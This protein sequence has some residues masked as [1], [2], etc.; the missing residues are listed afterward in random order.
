MTAIATLTEN[1]TGLAAGNPITTASTIFDKVSGAGSSAF[2][3]D[4]FSGGANRMMRVTN[5]G[6]QFRIHEMDFAAKELLWFTFD[7]AIEDTVDSNTAILNG[8]QTNAATAAEKIF[9]LQ[10]VGGATTLRLRSINTAIWTS[11]ALTADTKYRVYV[12]VK[13][14]ASARRLRVMVYDAAGT[15]LLQD[16]GELTATAAAT[17]ISHLRLGT[18]SDS[19]STLLFGRLR[20]DDADGPAVEVAPAASVSLATNKPTP[21]PGETVTLTAATTGTGT[22]AFTQT[23][24]PTVTLSG[25]GTTRTFTAPTHWP[26]GSAPTRPTLTFQ[27]AYGG[28]TQAVTVTPYAHTRWRK[29]GSGWQAV[30]PARKFP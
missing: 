1:F 13:L 24:G 30:T 10:I 16:S 19:T 11:T 26:S 17:S 22:L 8:Y 21:E 29:T 4:P 27:A 2:I 25:S 15:T 20:G 6:A 9:D 3:V 14:G 12:M 18:I 28:A 5:A 23:A 7:L